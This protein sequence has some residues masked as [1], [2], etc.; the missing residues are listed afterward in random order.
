[1]S[2]A[3]W[4]SYLRNF[5]EER[6]GITEDILGKACHGPAVFGWY[7]LTVAAMTG[8]LLLTAFL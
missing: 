5:H 8:V 7:R 2:D 3:T 1:M 6:P 4:G